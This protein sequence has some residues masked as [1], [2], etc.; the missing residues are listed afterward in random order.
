M[1]KRLTY[2]AL[3]AMC[4]VN[5]CG[6][7]FFWYRYADR[8]RGFSFNAPRWW[9]IKTDNPLAPLMLLSPRHGRNDKFRE[10]ITVTSAD[11]LVPEIV[12]MFWDNNKKA[13]VV[14][15]PG[16]KSNF[17]EGE[18]YAG[19]NPG[20][21]FSFRVKG[22]DLDLTIKTVAWFKGTVVYCATC[23]AE[24]DKYAAYSPIFEKML[25]SFRFNPPKSKAAQ[26]AR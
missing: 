9:E 20:Q 4:L 5:C 2:L 1:R 11:L 21:F 14:S 19:M 7:H 15:L 23:S 16:Y 6:C 26:Q 13:V 18:F 10:N 12:E 3:A 25:A 24:T 17:Q 8:E 22:K